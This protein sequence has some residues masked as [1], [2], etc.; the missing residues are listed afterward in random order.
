M[1]IELTCKII[2]KILQ[3]KMGVLWDKIKYKA[4][5]IQN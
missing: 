4:I 5:K 1:P 2:I 3:L